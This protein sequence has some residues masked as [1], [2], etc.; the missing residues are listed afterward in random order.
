MTDNPVEEPAMTTT[1][2]TQPDRYLKAHD[3]ARILTALALPALRQARERESDPDQR[4]WLDAAIQE[5]QGN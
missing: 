4:W 2:T 1:D 5:C 3:W